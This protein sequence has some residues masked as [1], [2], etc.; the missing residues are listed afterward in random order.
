MIDAKMKIL[1]HDKGVRWDNTRL[2][3]T[4][5]V[6]A[7]MIISTGVAFSQTQQL[8]IATDKPRYG[9]GEIIRIIGTIPANQ[10]LEPI[11]LQVFD[12]ENT[13]IFTKVPV[14]MNDGT[15]VVELNLTDTSIYS[16]A[17]SG[18]YT[19]HATYGE[20]D[21]ETTFVF[22]GPDSLPPKDNLLVTFSDG[23]SQT[24]EAKLST[25]FITRISALE[26][27]QVLRFSLATNQEEGEL[28]VVLPRELIDSKYETNEAGM[29]EDN[30]FTVL[31]DG[32]YADYSE[33][34]TTSETRTLNILIPAGTQEVLIE[35]SSIMPEF[36]IA[37]VGIIATIIGVVSVIGRTR[38]VKGSI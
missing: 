17:R 37:L 25:G 27:A 20:E 19:V 22:I 18:V 12:P 16:S 13:A 34:A 24:V 7:V 28:T 26:E 11:I 23:T 35:G 38:L 33:S 4:T 3:S 10:D 15:F 1:N 31:A 9:V 36:P 29:Q 30:R 21:Q 6:I 8:S 5:L 14:P 32:D 2:M